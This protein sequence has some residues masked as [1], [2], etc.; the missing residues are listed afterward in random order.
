MMQAA[1]RLEVQDEM[2]EAFACRFHQ[3]IC[4]RSFLAQAEQF[5]H[6]HSAFVFIK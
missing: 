3:T 5:W 6:Q 4:E 2:I 1:V